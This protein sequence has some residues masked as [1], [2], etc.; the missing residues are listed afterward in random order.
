MCLSVLGQ[1]PDSVL[2]VPLGYSTQTIPPLPSPGQL[3]ISYIHLEDLGAASSQNGPQGNEAKSCQPGPSQTASGLY[4]KAGHS[5]PSSVCA[6]KAQGR[7]I[8]GS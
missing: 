2:A 8:L 7:H 3:P 4:G 6:Y 5:L 1:G